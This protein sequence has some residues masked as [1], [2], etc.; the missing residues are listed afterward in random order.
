MSSSPAHIEAIAEALHAGLDRGTSVDPDLRDADLS[1]PDAYAVAEAVRIKRTEA[2]ARTT[3]RKIG[4][5][6][7]ETAAAFGAP[8]PIWGWVYNSTLRSH[9][10]ARTAI[11]EPVVLD[12]STFVEPRLEPEIVLGLA[13]APAAGMNEVELASC[14]AWAAPGFEIVQSVFPGWRFTAAEAVAGHGLHGALI[15]GAPFSVATEPKATESYG[16][17][18]PASSAAPTS[19]PGWL[20]DVVMDL[21]R[22]GTAIARGVGSNALGGPLRALRWL[23]DELDR[24]GDAPLVAGEIVTTGTLTEAHPVGPGETWNV[25]SASS[26]SSGAPLGSMTIQFV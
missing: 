4:F 20:S 2:G 14:V 11:K 15:V 16:I 19:S 17:P 13:R 12:L 18:D 1:L 25:V 26:E 24:T 7:A 3:G 9:E 22:D 21:S 8:G 6:N 10:R 23:V 5:T